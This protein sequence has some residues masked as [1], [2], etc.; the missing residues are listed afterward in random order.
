[1]YPTGVTLL[2]EVEAEEDRLFGQSMYH[3]LS[4]FRASEG[5]LVVYPT[6]VD[7]LQEVEAEEDRL[8]REQIQ[9]AM[10]CVSSEKER[11]RKIRE[12]RLGITAKT[13]SYP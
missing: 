11:Y 10:G 2:Q 13:P 4:C 8:W 12:V 5:D 7:V 6:G 1:M 3:D 9:A